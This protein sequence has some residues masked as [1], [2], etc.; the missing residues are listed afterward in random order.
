MTLTNNTTNIQAI[1]PQ[2]FSLTELL[3][4]KIV[5]QDRIIGKLSDLVIKDDEKVA[6]VISILV[7]RSFGDPKLLIPWQ[8]VQSIQNGEFIVNL[9]NL[10]DYENKPN[11]SDILLK[12]HVL[13]KKVL[14]LEG[15]E[16]ELVYDV[17][18][19]YK[20]GKMYVIGVDSSRYG[21]LKR[22]H[23]KPLGDMFFGNL[24][25]KQLIPW[26]YIAPLSNLDSFDG[27][28][29]LNVLKDKID[30]FRPEDLADILEEMDP[31]QRTSLFDTLDAEH[32]SDTLEQIDP[33]VQREL[34]ASL[35]KD[36]VVDLISRMTSAQAA[37]VLSI[38]P[39]NEKHSIMSQF[40]EKKSKKI[41]SILTKQEEHVL[42]YSTYRFIQISAD[43]TSGWVKK[44]FTKLSAGTKE[45]HYL[46]VLDEQ[47]HLLGI[48]SLND[49]LVSNDTNKVSE[50]MAKSIIKLKPKST[51]K[52]AAEIFSRY[53][54]RAIP[55]VD[56][57]NK[58]LGTLS[59]RDVMRLSHRFIG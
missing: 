11:D 10:K 26:K 31:K 14:D 9:E 15:K 3:G 38:L 22:M 20:E 7:K 28:L 6:T 34:I 1:K 33:K 8:K 13:D 32:A 16:F 56:E 57:E 4:A 23:L 5:L 24:N 59:Y 25:R 55:V 50:I 40:S 52:R 27:E 29:K 30:D 19:G 53:D 2:I 37:D 12:D 41:N 21:L 48:I 46:Y 47:N 51:L 36:K 42:N 45:Y 49:L 44:N 35:N 39:W 17:Q 58:M 18:L 43:K 54:L